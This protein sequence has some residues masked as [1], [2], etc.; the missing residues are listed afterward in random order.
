MDLMIQQIVSGGQ[1]GADRAALDWAMAHGIPH[2]GWCPKGRLAE[3]GTIPDRYQLKETPSSDYTQRTEWNVRDSDATLVINT[4]VLEGGTAL[5]VEIAQRTG[6]P[7]LRIQYD[8]LPNDWATRVGS[9]L[10]AHE[11]KVINIAGPRE[12]SRPGIY[13]ATYEMLN[14]LFGVLEA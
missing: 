11:F 4:G 10:R 8:D 14:T 1:T 6:K 13:K 7:Y 9:W 2:G 3:D 12:S 5:T